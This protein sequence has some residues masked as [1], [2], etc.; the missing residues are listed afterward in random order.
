MS[1]SSQSGAATARERIASRD[2]LRALVRLA[3]KA[4]QAARAGV[5]MGALKREMPGSLGM[6]LE[7]R[8]RDTPDRVALV[9]EGQQWTWREFNAWSN[10]IAARLRA[11]GV[12]RGDAVGVLFENRPLLLALV[13]AIVKLGAVA[14]MLN[15][16]QR[17]DA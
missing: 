15:P 8:A 12:A 2:L 14:G 10:R 13:A 6:L 3:P 11:A 7:E 5:R 16:N 1:A 4:R 17:E 9:F